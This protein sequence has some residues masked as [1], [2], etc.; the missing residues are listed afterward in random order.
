MLAL[1]KS[2]K[3]MEVVSCAKVE[4]QRLKALYRL[5]I[6]DTAAEEDFDNI[7]ELAAQICQTPIANIAFIDRDRSWFKAKKGVEFTEVPRD[8]SFCAYQLGEHNLIEIEDMKEHPDFCENPAVTGEPHIRYY[9]AVSI[10]SEE[11][12]TVG[13]LCVLDQTPRKLSQS[14][15]NA[16][17]ILGKQVEKLLE[18]RLK[19]LK[20]EE[21]EETAR[22]SEETMNLIFNNAID[23]VIVFDNKGRIMQWN[24]KAEEVF[25]W[26]KDEALGKPFNET[27]IAAPFREEHS[28]R[29]FNYKLSGD[30]GHLNKTV[31]VQGLR[32]DKQIIDIALGISPTNIKGT[33]FF[34]CFAN[35]ITE[36]KRVTIEL[37]KQKAFYENILNHIPTDIAVFD[38]D[39]KYLF[40]NPG[41]IKND[42]LRKYIIGK[43][44][45]EYAEYRKRDKHT[46]EKRR[47]KFL[48]AKNSG[49]EIR[50]ED[51]LKDPEGN[52]ITHLRRFFPVF[53]QENEFEMM[54]GFGIDIT[55]RK[56]LEE[57]QSALVQQLSSQNKQ[58]VDFCNIV[59]HNLR[60][61]LVNMSMLVNCI[62][63][64]KEE[65]EQKQLIGMLNPV[66][67]N[68]HHTF[69]ELVESIQIKQDHEIKSEKLRFEDCLKRTL[70]GFDVEMRKC[71][72][73]IEYDFTDAECVTYPS[74]YLYSIVHNLISNALKY[75]SP[76]R[77]PVILLKTKKE[78]GSI[79]LSVSDNGLGMDLTKHKDKIFKIGKVFHSHPNAKGFGLFMTKTQVEAMGGKIWLEST[80][81]QGST[82]F[83]EL[84][85]QQ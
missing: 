70:H 50:Y 27:I 8:A 67:E 82:F 53:N 75:Q 39:H 25:G 18:L 49:K 52:S 40:V 78:E 41:A 37:D 26:T 61:P 23:A 69:S 19:I 72:A 64:S 62:E 7:T 81:D 63:E 38:R 57:K 73:K 55:E 68:L 30:D 32:K 58:L 46:A 79:I 24:P 21:A 16:L 60:G 6:L 51:S 48:E 35:D 47:L 20:L 14:Q 85:N 3:G 28:D 13:H 34:I 45:F 33:P 1:K 29:I 44:D 4:V 17:H 10:N 9:A 77:N 59:S 43:D 84:V 56:I 22:S 42:E 2:A 66:I 15:L 74:K 5:K 54:I 36:R 76:E 11:G 80:P 12:L 71:G 65:E 31:E 83:I